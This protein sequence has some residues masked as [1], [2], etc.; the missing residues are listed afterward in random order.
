MFIGREKELN[1][2]TEV[3]REKKGKAKGIL[4]W[5]VRRCGKSTLIKEAMKSF[6]GAFINME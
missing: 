4:V 2:I 1:Q 3:I 5:G 6:D